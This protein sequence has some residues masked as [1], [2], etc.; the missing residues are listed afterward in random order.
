[1]GSGRVKAVLAAIGVLVLASLAQ[2][3]P[4]KAAT[5]PMYGWGSN[6]AGELGDGTTTAS[7]SPVAVAGLPSPVRQVTTGLQMSA[8]VLTNGT[9]WVWGSDS[10]GQL[11]IG[12]A[13]GNVTTPVQ[14][15][16]LSGVTQVALSG[17]GSG[18][19]VESNGTL[20]AWG[21]N[22]HGQ[23][24][25]GT[26]TNSLSPMQVGSL[27]GIT[28][29]AADGFHT[30]ALGTDG[31]VYSWG[32]NGEGE[33]GDGTTTSKSVPEPILNGVIQVAAAPTASFAVTAVGTLLDWGAEGFGELGDGR[34][35]GFT[36]APQQ[37]GGLSGVRQ[38][39]SDGF[40]TMAVAGS[41]ET[42]W[43]WGANGCG[44]LGDGTTTAELTP[45]QIGLPGTVQVVVGIDFV[46][47]N[48]SAAV[49]S[50]GT[51]WTWGCDASGQL[52][53]GAVTA[54]QPTP[55]QVTAL[56]GVAQ[57]AFGDATTGL[58]NI[59]AYGL[60]VGLPAD[61]VP[62][63]VGDSLTRAGT[64]LQAAGL[65]LG[66]VTGVVDP[67]CNHI[68]IVLSQSP[69]AGTRVFP[70]TAVSVRVGTRPPPPRLCP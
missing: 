67:T 56:A 10:V 54:A 68:G 43:A 15:P 16:G 6:F 44:E 32:D 1:M 30:L 60:A 7:L 2:A 36:D 33:L 27:S 48:F 64:V 40:N 23:L 52:G 38:V 3:A 46:F 55:K 17:E 8:A 70:G 47:N 53:Y 13:G 14:V 28:Q 59:G 20:W 29:V 45:E 50:D 49:R 24:G 42:V 37:V 69:A 31:T 66:S 18:F 25:N 5:S 12:S 39:V 62:N 41:T 22:S 57:F 4:A 19:A 9:V 21:D 51:L 61:T 34:Q 35:E 11:G 26:T 58:L 65:S 63:L